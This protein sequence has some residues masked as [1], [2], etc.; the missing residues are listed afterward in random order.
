[1]S[2]AAARQTPN[3]YLDDALVALGEHARRFADTRVPRGFLTRPPTRLLD[4]T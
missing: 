4:A 2:A 3:P 1:M